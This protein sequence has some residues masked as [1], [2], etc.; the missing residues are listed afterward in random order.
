MIDDGEEL[1]IDTIEIKRSLI[2]IGCHKM[3]TE[4]KYYTHLNRYEAIKWA[5]YLLAMAGELHIGDD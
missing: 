3:C 4:E 5:G 2:K 1:V